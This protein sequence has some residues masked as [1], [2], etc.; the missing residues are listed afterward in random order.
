MRT[1]KIRGGSRVKEKIRAKL[2]S[3][4]KR[5][6]SSRKSRISDRDKSYRANNKTRNYLI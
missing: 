4:N 6:Q 2:R 3:I 5:R 1:K